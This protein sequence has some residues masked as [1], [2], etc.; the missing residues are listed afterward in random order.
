[1]DA[2]EAGGCE[3]IGPG[4]DAAV[5]VGL[6]GAAGSA[7]SGITDWYLLSDKPA[8]R[9]GTLHM[10]LNVSATVLY[11]AS[12]L[13]RRRGDRSSGRIFGWVGY[14]IVCSSAFLGGALVYDQ[15]I[16][17]DH[18]TREGL[19]EKFV[20]AIA[21]SDLPENELKQVDVDGVKI[22]LVRQ[23]KDV[24]ALGDVCSHLGG[25]LSEGKLEGDCVTCP[26]H[27]SKFALSTGKVV[28]G[29]ATFPQPRFETRV[30]KGQIEVR[31][32]TPPPHQNLG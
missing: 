11:G 16:G 9:I 10:L 22:L 21:D 6:A 25:P 30:R 7:L 1:M 18:A 3:Q 20:P 14:A 23:G 4:A 17:V 2:M 15:K 5:A 24:F 13:M 26:W 28:N 32:A 27:A 19:P 29:P 8:K 12:W 31:V